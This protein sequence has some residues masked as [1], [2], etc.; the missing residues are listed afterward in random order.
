M[1]FHIWPA[2]ANIISRSFFSEGLP[3]QTGLSGFSE[4]TSPVVALGHATSVSSAPSIQKKTIH[5]SMIR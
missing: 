4:K 1:V 2:I 5:M 3:M